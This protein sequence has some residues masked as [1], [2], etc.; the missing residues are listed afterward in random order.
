MRVLNIMYKIKRY[1]RDENKVNE[2]KVLSY[3]VALRYMQNIIKTMEKLL[4]I[5]S[6]L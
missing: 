2:N 5:M 4:S 1:L 3:C 6:N